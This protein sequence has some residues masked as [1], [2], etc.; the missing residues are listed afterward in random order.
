MKL[1]NIFVLF[2]IV[3]LL[4]SNF[5][6]F[7]MEQEQKGESENLRPARTIYLLKPKA[8]TPE[9]LERD[10]KREID[11]FHESLV[12]DS[13]DS[14]FRFNN[15]GLDAETK[16]SMDEF[17]ASLKQTISDILENNKPILIANL[18]SMISSPEVITSLTNAAKKIS[19]DKELAE[20]L[21]DSVSVV[22]NRALT[23]PVLKQNAKEFLGSLLRDPQV[24]RDTRSF[25]ENANRSILS[26]KNLFILIWLIPAIKA[27]RD[28]APYIVKYLSK[29]NSDKIQ[30]N[31]II[32][33]NH[34][35]LLALSIAGVFSSGLQ[36]FVTEKIFQGAKFTALGMIWFTRAILKKV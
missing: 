24:A 35:K 1:K 4:Q 26:T 29:T 14:G 33:N 13:S 18:S 25:I 8:K 28:L 2:S 17:H 34:S 30:W 9:E 20:S 10:R 5:L 6:S 11:E 23:N 22:L 15:R 7:S 36:A 12:S 16:R 21:G 31:K 27:S 32:N 19:E 3:F